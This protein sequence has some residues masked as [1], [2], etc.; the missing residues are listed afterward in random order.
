MING[1]TVEQIL[2]SEAPHRATG[3]PLMRRAAAGLAAEVRRLINEHVDGV[4]NN[5]ATILVLAGSGDNGGDA[6]FAGAELASDDV[7]IAV[8]PTGSRL[9]PEALAAAVAAGARVLHLDPKDDT[10]VGTLTRL[11]QTS[12]M[13]LDAI[14]GTGTSAQ[15][16]LRGM[17]RD[18]VEVL[19]P[20][21]HS[22]DGPIVVA[23]DIPSGIGPDDGSVPNVAVL[24]A[25]VTV[26][27]GGCKTGLLRGAGRLMA[28]RVVVVDIGTGEDLAA[29]TP[30]VTGAE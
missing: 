28:G 13:V 1:Y 7:Q 10:D 6:L 9:H 14:V 29:M 8:V 24:R 27:F 12:D 21:L 5:G 18:I 25:D 23:V 3:E 22:P 4:D 11:A 15:P 16:A 2:A 19:R 20:V 17:A 26:T 30:V